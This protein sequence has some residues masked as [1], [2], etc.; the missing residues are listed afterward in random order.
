MMP[1]K[2]TASYKYTK[3]QEKLNHLIYMDGIKLFSK[4]EKE[5]ETLIKTLRI[6][7]QD[8]GME[9]SI[10][11]CDILVMKYD[12]RHMMEG[13]ELRNQVAIRTLGEKET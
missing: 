13:T 10:E 2:C 3:S 11:K 9:F 1:L 8:I 12:K 7:S 6:L 5:L 4:N